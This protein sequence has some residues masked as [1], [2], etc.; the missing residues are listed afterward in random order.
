MTTL[1][2]FELTNLRC[3][4][5]WRGEFQLGLN[6]ITGANGAGKTSLLEAI[7][8]LLRQRSFRSNSNND[9][10]RWGTEEGL[11]VGRFINNQSD[12][13]QIVGLCRT[14]AGF[15]SRMNGE[16]VRQRSQLVERFPLVTITP[17][18]TILVNGGPGERRQYL[19]QTLFHVEHSFL[20]VWR[21][22][23]AALSQRNAILRTGSVQGL[24]VWDAQLIQY[25]EALHT[26]RQSLV[27]RLRAPLLENLN[28]LDQPWDVEIEYRTGWGSV[29]DE[30][31][32]REA[33]FEAR[34]NDTRRATTTR[35]P[36]RAELKII[37]ENKPVVESLSRGQQ[38]LLSVAL[39]TTQMQ[40]I[41]EK[42][43]QIPLVLIDDVGAELDHVNANKVIDL[44]AS[45][46]GQLLVTA[47][48]AEP[49]ATADREVTMF[50]VER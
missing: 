45:F 36:H 12:K 4:P 25:G 40:L 42:S 9:F 8:L 19:D 47:L 44:C 49:Y 46:G 31:Q 20:K 39:L 13:E 1:R 22:Y 26:F 29:W 21:N 32:F 17:A 43:S 10:V 16:P 2:R 30:D 37:S 15:T 7:H 3:F 38:R 27:S 34:E 24:D 48:E 5:E 50:H 33:L 18:T 35:G 41:A 11:I 6:L 28:K 14:R 23:R